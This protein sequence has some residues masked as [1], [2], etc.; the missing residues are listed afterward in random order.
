MTFS[1]DSEKLSDK[2]CFNFQQEPCEFYLISGAYL[3]S[4]M[5]V[6]AS[7]ARVAEMCVCMGV[8]G[9]DTWT[10]RD[11]RSSH[12]SDASDREPC[13]DGECCSVAHWSLK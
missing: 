9:M 13:C 5:R 3:R 8:L 11:V 2:I 4:P 12:A 7:R 6:P 10:G 1:D